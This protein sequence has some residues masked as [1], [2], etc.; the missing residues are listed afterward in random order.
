MF[1]SLGDILLDLHDGS[2]I[3]VGNVVS[4]AS[5][6]ATTSATH[7]VSWLITLQKE[8]LSPSSAPGRGR[9]RHLRRSSQVLRNSSR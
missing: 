7:A 2:A 6:R 8:L 4:D 9:Y 3:G 5:K 1:V